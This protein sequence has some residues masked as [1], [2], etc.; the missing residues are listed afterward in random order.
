MS[1]SVYNSALTGPQLDE[2]LQIAAQLVVSGL[3]V[4]RGGIGATY[5]APGSYLVGNGTSEVSL[6]TPAEVLTDIGAAPAGYG[7]GG[8][9]IRKITTELNANSFVAVEDTPD[10]LWAWG[11]RVKLN[12]NNVIEEV[13]N[14][15]GTKIRRIWTNGVAGE[16]EYVNPPMYV[17]VEY[18][19]T[20]R[21]NG[22]PIYRQLVYYGALPTSTSKQVA[23]GI[24][25]IQYC[26][27][28]SIRNMSGSASLTNYVYV[29]AIYADAANVTIQT[30][31]DMSS[32]N[33]YVEV[34]Y[35]KN[36]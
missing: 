2:A 36:E 26:L 4:E 3:P 34:V 8:S 14:A 21:Y 31:G 7:L 30:T 13:T 12:D 32:A 33:A 15:H 11:T 27:N 20:E 1:E 17:G 18:R 23:H 24:S 19:T 16:W 35:T 9:A 28:A 29:D 22:A 6:K 25:G 5:L 10:A